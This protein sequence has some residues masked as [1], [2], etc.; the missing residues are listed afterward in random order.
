MTTKTAADYARLV[1]MFVGMCPETFDITACAE[2]PCLAD[3]L[4]AEAT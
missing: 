4:E 3:C 1:A 2:C